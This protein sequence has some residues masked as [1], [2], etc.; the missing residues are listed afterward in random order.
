M[1][2]RVQAIPQIEWIKFYQM[3]LMRKCTVCLF[4]L[5]AFFGLLLC[6]CCCCLLLPPNKAV[7]PLFHSCLSFSLHKNLS[8]I[9]R[10]AEPSVFASQRRA[11]RTSLP[12]FCCSASIWGGHVFWSVFHV[13]VWCACAPERAPVQLVPHPFFWPVVD[14][15][16]EITPDQREFVEL[17]RKF[18]REEV[19]PVAAELDRTGEVGLGMSWVVV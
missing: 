6:F 15:V 8:R 12:V 14:A 17:A 2:N 3:E 16:A 7:I 11:R 10:H 9:E 18:A 1:E 19:M 5:L 13:Y 4:E